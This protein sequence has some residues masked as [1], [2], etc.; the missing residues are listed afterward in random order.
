MIPGVYYYE[1]VLEESDLMSQINQFRWETS[2]ATMYQRY[3]PNFLGFNTLPSCLKPLRQQVTDICRMLLPSKTP[4]HAY[5]NECLILQYEIGEGMAK[6]YAY[7][8]HGEVSATF[9]V[10][11]G[12]ILLF[13]NE[14]HT[15]ELYTR[16]NSLYLLEGDASWDWS[17]EMP[18]VLY[19]TVK[20][21]KV[22][23]ERRTTITF[24]H[25]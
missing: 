13:S 4:H 7:P 21:E 14:D 25:T 3:K 20:G 8:T 12:A 23:R 11:G 5:F 18:A 24:R 17:S 10:G 1:N 9:V 6:H 16:H 19:D 22:F 15:E 2:G